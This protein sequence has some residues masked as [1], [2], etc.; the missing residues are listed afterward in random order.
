M[1]QFPSFTNSTV[2]ASSPSSPPRQ[3]L[4]SSLELLTAATSGGFM[5]ASADPYSSGFPMPEFKPS[6]N[7]S[8]DGLG[9]GYGSFQGVPE[10]NGKLLFPFEDLKQVPNNADQTRDDHNSNGFWNGVIGGGSW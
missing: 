8:L 2:A 5:P 1:I 7:F 3:H 6:L 9:S 10:A 4:S